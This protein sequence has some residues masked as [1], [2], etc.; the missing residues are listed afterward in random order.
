M[1]VVAQARHYFGLHFQEPIRIT[2]VPP[3]LG[4]RQ[5]CLDLSFDQVRGMTPAQALL[6]H[7][8]N[9]LFAALTERPQQGLEPAIAACG[10]GGTSGVVPLFEQTFGI[11]MPA[12]LLTCR[13]AAEDRLFRRQHREPEALVLPSP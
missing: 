5:H 2:E 10:L 4:I 6:E 7:R 9:R 12:F 11:E 1:Q 8:L 13:Q 3:A